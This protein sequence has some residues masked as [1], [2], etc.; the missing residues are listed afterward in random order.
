MGQDGSDEIASRSLD[1]M[2]RWFGGF[3]GNMALHF[4]AKGGVY[5]AGGLPT[6]I[7]ETLKKEAFRE[8]FDGVGE[9]SQY[10]KDVAV[11]ALKPAA[12]PGLRGAA[13]ALANSLPKA[14][15]PHSRL[16]G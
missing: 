12:D 14:S 13:V 8:A 4:G 10:L 1:L 16:R 7:V 2:S 15:R 11:Y 9:R 6:G 5:L 3:A